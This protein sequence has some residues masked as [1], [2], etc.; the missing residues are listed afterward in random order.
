MADPVTQGGASGGTGLDPKVASLLAYLCSPFTGLIFLLLEKGNKDVRLHAWHSIVFGVAC[1]V[2]SIAMSV[3][4]GIMISISLALYG[5]F[6]IL[7]LVI[8][9]GEFILWVMLMVRAYQGSIL[10]IPVITDLAR[11]QAEK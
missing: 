9:L 8:S 6:N 4:S 2:V 1:I 7:N 10:T 5:A 3:V 11:K